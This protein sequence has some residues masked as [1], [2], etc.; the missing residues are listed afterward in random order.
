MRALEYLLN[1]R[2]NRAALGSANQDV[3]SLRDNILGVGTSIGKIHGELTKFATSQKWSN[4]TNLSKNVI[5]GFVNVGRT[6]SRAFQASFNFMDKFAAD[7]DKVAKSARLVGMSVKDYQAFSFAADRSGI[8]LEAFSSGLQRFSVNLG[9]ARS[10]DKTAAKMFESLLPGKLSDYKS[11]RDV[12]LAMSDSYTK[13]SEAQRN[14]VSQ[15][16][17]GRSGLRFGEL[18]SGGS[19]GVQNLLSRYEELGGGFGDDAAKNAEKFKD[20]LADVRVTLDALR[21]TAGTELL[22]VFNELFASITKYFVEN[23]DE[24]RSTFREFGKSFVDGVKSIIP[25]IPSIVSGLSEILSFVTDIVDTIG[26]IKTIL[27]VGIIGSLGSIVTIVTSLVGLIGGPAVA[28]V[29]LVGAGI[30]SLV[31]IVKQFYDNWDMLKSF[32]VDDVVPGIKNAFFDF[33][34][35][36]S[37]GFENAFS[38]GIAKGVRGAIK[39]IPGIGSLLFSDVN[40]EEGSSEPDIGG[41]FEKMVQGQNTTTTSRFSVDFKNM[42]RGVKVNAPKT[43]DF[44]YSYGY[45]LD[46]GF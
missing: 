19:E 44:D 16:I 8:A 41:N 7:G 13:L 18:F 37:D 15:S 31:S 34:G 1:F 27:A 36:L 35:W 17:F 26:P 45:V 46:G 20:E 42:P 39:S 23:R 28:A 38:S 29:A 40:F 4:I 11:E 5:G 6:V 3:R 24:I 25:K 21:I 2:T 33:F 30:V 43:G 32:I 9:K 12:L 22:P 14:F 10:G